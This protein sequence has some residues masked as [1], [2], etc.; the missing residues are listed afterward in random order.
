MMQV[1]KIED[2]VDG[3]L[4]MRGLAREGKEQQV[5][6]LLQRLYTAIQ[7][8][9]LMRMDEKELVCDYNNRFT[10]VFSLKKFL[11]KGKK[12]KEK[13]K[14]PL[15]PSCKER[16][17]K[18]KVQEITYIEGLGFD[19]VVNGKQNEFWRTLLPFM[20]KYG[21]SMLERFQ[22]YW[23]A[24]VNGTTTLLWET[25]KSWSVSYRLKS[26][27]KSHQELEAQVSEIR[28]E[29]T[30]K[31]SAPQAG[32]DEGQKLLAAQREEANARLEQEIRARK[33]GAVSYEEYIRRKN[34][35]T[36]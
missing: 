7:M 20:E 11:K 27:S 15:H 22:A 26:W 2:Y 31:K 30:R 13:E 10:D 5:R 6:L 14:S 36:T 24:P 23:A 16:E 21:Q 19:S 3:V 25:K 12:R 18:E 29:R 32:N 1:K 8:Y 33:Q 35:T 9:R 28:L 4:E 17:K 34:K